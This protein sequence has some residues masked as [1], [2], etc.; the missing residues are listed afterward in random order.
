MQERYARK[1]EAL[2]LR[3]AFDVLDANKD[4]QIDA[5]E[6]AMTFRRLGHKARTVRLLTRS[7]PARS[8]FGVP[9]LL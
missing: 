5:D 3:R 1:N 9:K 4:G 8:C 7:Y 6:L 2:D